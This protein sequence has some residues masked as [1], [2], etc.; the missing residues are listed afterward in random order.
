MTS[1]Q[2]T[3]PVGECPA[4]ALLKILGGKWKARIF[5]LAAEAPLRFS[6]LL[7]QVPGASRQSLSAALKELEQAGLIKRHILSHKPL[8]TEY[9]LTERGQTLVPVFY[10]LEGISA[11]DLPGEEKNGTIPEKKS[12][13]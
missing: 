13:G 5:R 8:H 3:D 10:R 6:T 11:P 4:E 12:G 7:R 2:S 9:T 1:R